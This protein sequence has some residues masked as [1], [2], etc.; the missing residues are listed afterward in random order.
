MGKQKG[1]SNNLNTTTWSW[2][3]LPLNRTS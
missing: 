2:S 1:P 3:H